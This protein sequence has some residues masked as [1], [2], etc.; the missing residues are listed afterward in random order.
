MLGTGLKPRAGRLTRAVLLTSALGLGLLVTAPA[1]AANECGPAPPGGGT[2]TC[3]PAGNN[4]SDGVTYTAPADLT[5][6]LDP[7]VD[8]F[9]TI[10]GPSD[11]ALSVNASGAANVAVSARYAHIGA[12]SGL[13]DGVS[14]THPYGSTGTTSVYVGGFNTS[15][16]GQRRGI[17][18]YGGGN[19]SIAAFTALGG[20]AGGGYG[21]GIHVEGLTKGA[22]VNVITYDAGSSAGSG[23]R[24]FGA[25]DGDITITAYQAGGSEFGIVANAYGAG[26]VNVAVGRVATGNYESAILAQA[27]DGN[28]NVNALY[29]F[30]NSAYSAAIDTKTFG[31]GSINVTAPHV[32]AQRTGISAVAYGT[33]DVN[34]S[35]GLVRATDRTGVYAYSKSG[36]INVGVTRYAGGK[37]AGVAAV[38]ASGDIAI[39]IAS[40]GEAVAKGAYGS[41]IYASSGAGGVDINAAGAKLYATG[42]NGRGITAYSA[43]AKD[44]NINVGSVAALGSSTPGYDSD[45]IHV[46]ANGTGAINITAGTAVTYGDF[47]DAIFASG[48]GAI[49]VNAG[50]AVSTGYGGV[51]VEVHSTNGPVQVNVGAAIAI[52]DYGAG[53]IAHSGGDVSVTAG[54]ALGVGYGGH[55][56]IARSYGGNVSVGAGRVASYNEGIIATATGNGNVD[57]NVAAGG[58][59]VTVGYD[60]AGIDAEVDKG[61]INI[62]AGTGSVIG[63]LGSN[64]QG[65]YALAKGPG[66]INIAV[67]TVGTA[68]GAGGYHAPTAI[69]AHQLGGGNINISANQVAT[70]G[71]YARGIDA[72]ATTGQ[73]N[74]YTGSVATGGYAADAIHVSGGSAVSVI[75][76]G[77]T[78][79]L[80]DYA[81]GISVNT[82]GHVDVEN[83]GT[84]HTYGQGSTGIAV[85][86]INGDINIGSYSV[87]SEQGAAITAISSNGVVNVDAFYAAS[88]GASSS[89]INAF[90]NRKVSVYAGTVI[91]TGPTASAI[92]AGSTGGNVSVNAY[93]VTSNGFGIFAA[94]TAGSAHVGVYSSKSYYA[95]IT[96]FAGRD[97][98]VYVGGQVQTYGD[99]GTGVAVTAGGA[100]SIQGAQGSQIVTRGANADGVFAYARGAGDV[101]IDVDTVQTQGLFST[102]IYAVGGAGKLSV[103]S[104]DVSTKGFLAPGILAVG[105]TGPVSVVSGDVYT[106]GA[107]ANA[108]QASGGSSASVTTT[109]NTVTH[110]FASYGIFVTEGASPI[111]I[112][113]QGS[114]HTYGAY[115]NGIGASSISN[116][117]IV[118][119]QVTAEHGVGISALSAGDIDIQA[120]TTSAGGSYARGI[121]ALGSG[122]TV[123]ADNVSVSGYRSYGVVAAGHKAS[124][125]INPGGLATVSGDFSMGVQAFATQGDAKVVT[126][127]ASVDAQGLA[128]IGVLS[129]TKGAG[130]TATIQAGSTFVSG[131]EAFGLFD[132]SITGDATVTAQS[133]IGSGTRAVGI[134]AQAGA[135]ARITAGDVAVAGMRSV[136]VTAVG[137]YTN[138][139]PLSASGDAIVVTT[140]TVNA[141]GQNAVGVAALTGGG[142]VSIN[143]NVVQA[144]G[145]FAVGVRG[146]SLDGGQVDITAA[147]VSVT[148]YGAT[149][150][151]GRAAGGGGISVS[152]GHV[153]SELASAIDAQT[154]GG[155]VWVQANNVFAGGSYAAVVAVS[156]GS[157][158]GNIGLLTSASVGVEASSYYG[159]QTWTIG[160]MTAGTVGVFTYTGAGQTI[161]L[162]LGNV[163]AGDEAV[164]AGG[165][166]VNVNISA[167]SLVQGAAEPAIW[168][169]GAQSST[170][171]NAGTLRSGTGVAVLADTGP[172]TLNNSGMV[173]GSLVLAGGDD[174]FN[175][176]ATGTF[177]AASSDFGGGTNVFNNAGTLRFAA[178]GGPAGVVLGGLSQFNNSG[179]IDLSGRGPGDVLVI[180]GGFN[181]SGAS[182]L[183]VDAFLG[184]PGSVSDVLKVNG[185][186]TGSTAVKVHDTNPG[187]GAYNPTG[188]LVV[189]ASGAAA[190]PSASSFTLAGGPI[191]KGLWSYNLYAKPDKTF[192]LASTPSATAY[193]T[194]YLA[195][196]LQGLF[197]ASLLTLNDRLDD[198]RSTQFASNEPVRLAAV[199]SDIRT[200]LPAPSEKDNG[201]WAR[202][203]GGHETRD[204]T[205][206]VS[207]FGTSTTFNLGYRQSYVAIQSGFDHVVSRGPDTLLFGASLGYVDSSGDLV[208]GDTFHVSGMTG[209]VYAEYIRGGFY[210][211]L[212]GQGEWLTTNYKSSAGSAKPHSQAYGMSA[213]AGYRFQQAQWFF[214]PN[215]NLDW[216]NV[217][218]DPFTLQ[219]VGITFRDS[220]MLRGRAALN[221]GEVLHGAGGKTQIE[222][223]LSVGVVSAFEGGASAIFASGPGATLADNAHPTWGE[224]GFGVR[225]IDMGSGLSGFIRGQYDGLNSQ[226][227]GYSFKAGVKIRF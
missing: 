179:V 144:S 204:A 161:T 131:Y 55:G 130:A 56:I 141:T 41:A 94:S 202:I 156:P 217:N 66:S 193:D 215:A 63:T 166:H 87:T 216:A 79:T 59:V 90:S 119:N 120:N 208:A 127:G 196:A 177:A 75:T 40:G 188:I 18:V 37:S 28:V 64:G 182:Q 19:V 159:N 160:T 183:K 46:R 200:T 180:P 89:A 225:V 201:V 149:G 184:G 151:F 83:L 86:T 143:S 70:A 139:G 3:T 47:S 170:I 187:L 98:S 137:G 174:T 110:G 118:S 5:V 76:T 227:S 197:G 138:S 8:L 77:Y 222:P 205:Q 195:S 6:V 9:R 154:N 92:S 171:N 145:L 213:G 199:G 42:T 44:I 176:G 60:G 61:S 48:K 68:G 192:V 207:L 112:D 146:R 23:I 136:G 50:Y 167:G 147:D 140:G 106:S 125:T 100:I 142:D 181:G 189:D 116:I 36:D 65:I 121:Q 72:T 58:G 30:S 162:N 1:Y 88:H 27:D 35:A 97:A 218:V 194:P 105:T 185:A 16:Y 191:T 80:G 226:Y 103:T 133:T 111:S 108:I 172:V 21:D 54:V 104:N 38:S 2:V 206:T 24:V 74:I 123:T 14:V 91:A 224:F 62:T 51:G 164:I 52:G 115:A 219:G 117:S 163:S 29:A 168:L 39:N 214:E 186:I 81:A 134:R 157:V 109:G 173:I 221:I 32:Y 10:G 148:G 12:G 135:D 169:W 33:G 126:T 96:A 175:N 20:S 114:V 57:V 220:Q 212:V 53:V 11:N 45:A 223:T 129:E 69:F 71:D 22:S 84:V 13:Q 4:Y 82:F 17:N 25:E 7:G 49:N 102:G 153:S 67:D 128:T 43:G 15:V 26:N 85:S 190:T 152:A 178:S 107:L 73:V 165:G 122:V 95:G 93:N 124:V 211:H 150:I 132:A 210:G 158:G 34:I 209:A 31:A 101:T 203:V 78:G 99:H 198:L 155:D 113:N